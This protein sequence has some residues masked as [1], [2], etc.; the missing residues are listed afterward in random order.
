MLAPV[1]PDPAWRYR[2]GEVVHDL[3]CRTLVTGVLRTTLAPGRRATDALDDVVRE[4]EV[5]VGEGADLLEVPAA[6]G[7]EIGDAEE[8]DRVLPSIAALHARVDVA[9]ACSTASARVLDAACAAGAVVG[10]DI[11]GFADPD[12]LAVA[13]RHDASVVATRPRATSCGPGPD[14]HEAD[15]LLGACAARAEAAGLRP[16][17]ICVDAGLDLAS[18]RAQQDALLR[19]SAVLARH[20]HV[21]A[22]SVARSSS[23][24]GRLDSGPEDGREATL[25]SVAYG[26]MQGCRVVR[27]HDVAGSVQV[28]R[29]VE[30]ILAERRADDRPATAAS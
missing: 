19:G 17:Q 6:R 21:L 3:S 25:A 28:C 29:V 15:T 14:T 2:V 27:V 20:G 23:F 7:P 12:Y 26:V 30:A 11:S 4:A 18:S 16:E 8:L 22:L 10:R 24:G 5:L 13:V 9:L 1:L